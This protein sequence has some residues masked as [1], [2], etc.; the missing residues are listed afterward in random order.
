MGEGTNRVKAEPAPRPKEPRKLARELEHDVEQA[1]SSLDQSLAE[2][3]R[4][5]HEVL[6]LRLQV[7]RHPVVAA[8]AGA[9]VLGVVGGIVYAVW[10][11]QQRN[12]TIT[13]AQRLR[14]AISRMIDKPHKVAKSEPTVPEKVLGAIGTTAATIIVKKLLERAM[15]PS[16]SERPRNRRT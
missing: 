4:R 10:A 12:K 11:A 8:V 15:E 7:R 13:K 3:D 14:E 2:L 5:R 6:D 9:M 16:S 1:R